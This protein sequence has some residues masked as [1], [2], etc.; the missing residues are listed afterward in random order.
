MPY[1]LY[2]IL[3]KIAEETTR[4]HMPGHKGRRVFPPFDGV[5][6]VDFTETDATGNLYG[7]Q[8]DILSDAEKRA[9]SYFGGNCHF[10]TCGATQGIKAM[11]GAYAMGKTVLFDRNTHKSVV[12]ACIQLDIDPLSM[13]PEFLPQYGVTGQI[14]LS[15]LEK[16]LSETPNI[17]A[18]FLT[19]PTYYGYYHDI[20]AIVSV[21]HRHQVPVLVDCAHGAHLR[22]CG[23]ADPIAQGADCVVY[24]AHKT[25]DALTQGAYL[26][27][28]DKLLD[29]PLKRFAALFGTTSPS[30]PIMISL[31]IAREI[32][33]SMDADKITSLQK[34][35]QILRENLQSLGFS[36]P[37]LGD[38][39][40]VIL[41][42]PHSKQINDFFIA[43][44]IIPELCD[45]QNIVFIVTH[46]DTAMD[47]EKIY[48]LAKQ[49]SAQLS[50]ILSGHT[51]PPLPPIPER[52]LS[53]RK[54]FFS[55]ME[56]MPL[57]QAAGQIIGENL[58]LYPP[59]VPILAVGERI[60][61]VSLE[62]L[63]QIRY[64]IGKD[65]QIISPTNIQP[66][67]DA[68]LTER[69]DLL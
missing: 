25:L 1:T 32:A 24:S 28:Q 30:Y 5:Y 52:V 46:R 26:V 18:F 36:S 23:V 65:I 38:P 7:E 4:F 43:N 9:G 31:D 16:L 13:Q 12:D 2:N 67:E 45:G 20:A 51:F 44:G 66:A 19:S 35:C 41:S 14:D 27:F 53:P 60:D 11:L 22:L 8:P 10:L 40:R 42:S 47:L 29:K 62:Y 59:G 34:D 49:I 56:T 17:S 61:K 64:N 6:A 15:Y 33:Q 55:P 69:E 21:C 63:A 50:P 54:A 57:A 37:F 68:P 58:F 3:A 48:Q 39:L